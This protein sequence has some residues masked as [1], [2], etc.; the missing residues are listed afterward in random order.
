VAQQLRDFRRYAIVGIT[1][2]AAVLS[3]PDP[4]SLFAWAVL[5]VLLYETAILA[6]E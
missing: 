3:P 1:V 6:L 2:V 5:G 4:F